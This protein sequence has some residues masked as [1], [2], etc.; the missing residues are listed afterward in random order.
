MTFETAESNIRL[1]SW[2]ARQAG[3]I[4]FSFKTTE[5]HG[6]LLYNGANKRQLSDD[7]DFVAIEMY[8]GILYFVIN[9]GHGVSRFAFSDLR[10]DDG[11]SHSVRVERQSAQIT[12]TL[13]G[14]IRVETLPYGSGNL[15]LDGNP[16]YIGGYYDFSQLPW[17]L[18]TK[19]PKGIL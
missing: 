5:P 17:H 13:D 2:V 16:M 11:V 6:L 3:S 18:W 15:F 14:R 4:S 7:Q 8:D 9:T 12:L 19:N 10:L 1:S